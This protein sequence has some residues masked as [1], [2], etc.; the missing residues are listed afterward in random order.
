MHGETRVKNRGG[1][2]ENLASGFA[3]TTTAT[4]VDFGVALTGYRAVFSDRK[5][6]RSISPALEIEVELEVQY[7]VDIN[8]EVEMK[9]A[10]KVWHEVTPALCFAK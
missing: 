5:I 3:V 4:S 9:I 8:V 2:L 7:F 1:L 10:K 6:F